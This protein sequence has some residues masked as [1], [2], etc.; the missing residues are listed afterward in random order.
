MRRL[1]VAPEAPVRTGFVDIIMIVVAIL[2]DLMS[3]QHQGGASQSVSGLCIVP[4]SPRASRPIVFG[5][6]GM[7]A[8]VHASTCARANIFG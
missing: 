6:S 7:K 4:C 1:V 2:M 3:L 8:E 5:E